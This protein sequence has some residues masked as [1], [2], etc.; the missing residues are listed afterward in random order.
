MTQ[1]EAVNITPTIMSFHGGKEF[2]TTKISASHY[3]KIAMSVNTASLLVFQD[4]QDW[5][6]L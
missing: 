3:G 2:I 6:L 5:Y 4:R 1:A